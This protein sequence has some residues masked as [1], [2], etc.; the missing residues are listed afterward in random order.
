MAQLI[1]QQQLR[2]Q[3]TSSADSKDNASV[4]DSNQNAEVNNSAESQP[5]NGKVAQPKSENKAKVERW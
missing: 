1:N 3:K 4:N 5:T 2:A